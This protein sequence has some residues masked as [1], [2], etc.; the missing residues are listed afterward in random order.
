MVYSFGR[1]VTHRSFLQSSRGGSSIVGFR[2]PF[3]LLGFG[4]AMEDARWTLPPFLCFGCSDAPEQGH[5]P[6]Y[7]GL[8]PPAAAAACGPVYA[9]HGQGPSG[10]AGPSPT[11]GV[12]CTAIGRQGGSSSVR[13]RAS[14]G[15]VCPS[16]PVRPGA[17]R[18]PAPGFI[19]RTGYREDLGAGPIRPLFRSKE[20]L[21]RKE[22]HMELNEQ[23][24]LS[25]A[26]G[27]RGGCT[28]PVG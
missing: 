28:G 1:L 11:P 27:V 24:R 13:R 5:R 2:F 12:G 15:V 10:P 26:L 16:L 25:I 19:K 18:P 23:G 7:G 22:L 6:D 17:R 9:G 14:A 20:R 21:L 8:Q 3:C 4:L